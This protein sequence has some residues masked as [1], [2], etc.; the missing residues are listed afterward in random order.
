MFIGDIGGVYVPGLIALALIG[1]AFAVLTI[2]RELNKKVWTEKVI[3]YQKKPNTYWTY[4][5]SNPRH[6]MN[7]PQGPMD[8]L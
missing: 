1:T 4:M 6:T 7:Q 2:Y 5:K 8:Q 3:S